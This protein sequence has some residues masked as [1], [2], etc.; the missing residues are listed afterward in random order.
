MRSRRSASILLLTA[1]LAVGA[2]ACGDDSNQESGP[3]TTEVAAVATT[4]SVTDAPAEPATTTEPEATSE[5]ATT[6]GPGST[7]P[8]TTTEPETTAGPETAAPAT[9]DPSNTEEMTETD[10]TDADTTD[11]DTTDTDTTDTDT[12]DTDTTDTDTTD[13]GTTAVADVCDFVGDDAASE[14]TG[15][16]LTGATADGNEVRSVCTFSPADNDGVG[17]TIGLQ[18][19]SRFDDKAEISE[20]AVGPGV[21]VDDL[22][23]QALWFYDDEEDLGGTLVAVGDLTIDVTIQGLDGEA[24][25]RDAANALAALVV[26]G[27]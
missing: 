20:E 5:P 2:A 21:E 25:T 10:T 23:D 26:E 19:G 4:I 13:T 24:A 1:G 14:A 15:L 18:S 7:A 6:S 9:D 11:T 12:T 17:I 22:G 3:A 27:L 16:T 8:D